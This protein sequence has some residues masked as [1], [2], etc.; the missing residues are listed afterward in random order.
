MN[1]TEAQ[2]KEKSRRQQKRGL[3]RHLK[4]STS[5]LIIQEAEANIAKYGVEGLQIKSIAESLGISHP[6]IYIHYKNGRKEILAL[7]AANAINGLV[8]QFQ[9][10]G[11]SDPESALYSGV[12]KFVTHLTDNPAHVRILL[13]DFSIPGG[14]PAF[15]D[16]FGPP[17][18]T[19]R[20]GPLAPMAD[21]LTEILEK[22][23]GM[24]KFREYETGQLLNVILA[25]ALIDLAHPHNKST[26]KSL[27]SRLIDLVKHVLWP[28]G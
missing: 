24:G 26:S 19:E 21:R 2:R 28:T 1:D 9:Y 18:S 23:H 8:D 17:V 22:G 16:Q 4:A 5:E 10:D 3:K 13:H 7:V 12:E 27:H 11:K 20:T 6:A 14:L 25:V 15:S